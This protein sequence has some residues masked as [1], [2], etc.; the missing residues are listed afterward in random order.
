MTH[1]ALAETKTNKIVATKSEPN[2]VE[3]DWQRSNGRKGVLSFLSLFAQQL[4]GL[5]HGLGQTRG[6]G[7]GSA[8][9]AVWGGSVGV[10]LS[11]EGGNKLKIFKLA[12]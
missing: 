2:A 7:I 3:L 12:A 4:L 11:K 8:W 1:V 9:P 10:S 5:E 6:G